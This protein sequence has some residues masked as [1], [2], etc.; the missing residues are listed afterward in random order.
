MRAGKKGFAPFPFGLADKKREFPFS[1]ISNDAE[2]RG[3]PSKE[4]DL[5]ILRTWFC[6]TEIASFQE[7]G[8]REK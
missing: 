7:N 8:P 1:E 5:K 4:E 2:T 3:R 6:A